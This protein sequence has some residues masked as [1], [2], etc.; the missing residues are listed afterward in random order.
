MADNQDN[1]AQESKNEA[2][3]RGEAFYEMVRTKGWEFVKK[4]YEARIKSLVTSM[5]VNDQPITDF[6]NERRELIGIRNLFG[7]IEGDLKTL[8]DEK[9]S[10]TTKE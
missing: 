9:H 8:E 4:Y 2:C 10:G 3:V 5:L 7:F 6:E 1:L